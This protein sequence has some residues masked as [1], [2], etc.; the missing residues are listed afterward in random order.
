MFVPPPLVTQA[1]LGLGVIHGPRADPR[2]SA[3]MSLSHWSLRTASRQGSGMW[4]VTCPR[5]HIKG[6]A[7]AELYMPDP[8]PVLLTFLL[9]TSPGLS[10]LGRWASL[11]AKRLLPILLVVLWGP[12]I[13]CLLHSIL[14]IYGKR[15]LSWR[16][17]GLKHLD[18]GSQYPLSPGG[19]P[20]LQSGFLSVAM[21]LRPSTPWPC[22][23]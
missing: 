13:L 6:N 1:M 5:T 12:R 7:G 9:H 4:C 16:V 20:I 18:E 14:G 8:K 17:S 15:K 23:S 21:S 10:S 22:R 19:K 3:P 11:L 2:C